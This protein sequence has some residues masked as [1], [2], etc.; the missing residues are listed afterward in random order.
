MVAE[1][2]VVM[3]VVKTDSGVSENDPANSRNA[4]SIYRRIQYISRY[5]ATLLWLCRWPASLPTAV[6]FHI[7]KTVVY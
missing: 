6:A 1:A 3:V 2:G 5:V 4:P 7:V